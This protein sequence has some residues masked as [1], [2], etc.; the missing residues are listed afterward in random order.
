MTTPEA[1]Q[2]AYDGLPIT[3]ARI[4]AEKLADCLTIYRRGAVTIYENELRDGQWLHEPQ[5]A[6][7]VEAERA[8]P[9]TPAEAEA[10]REGFDKLTA[11]IRA[12]GRNATPA[13]IAKMDQLQAASRALVP[14]G[15]APAAPAFDAAHLLGAGGRCRCASSQHGFGKIRH[16]TSGRRDAE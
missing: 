8:R 7:I 4:E 11:L 16:R 5:A 9:M 3:L 12:P 14:P 1:H 6:A 10:Y 15:V 13:E 2:A